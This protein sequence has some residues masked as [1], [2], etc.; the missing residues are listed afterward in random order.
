MGRFLNVGGGRPVL[1]VARALGH[2]VRVQSTLSVSKLV[3][4]SSVP[5]SDAEAKRARSVSIAEET[6]KWLAARRAAEHASDFLIAKEVTGFSSSPCYNEWVDEYFSWSAQPV[7]RS[8]AGTTFACA[9][10]R[11]KVSPRVAHAPWVAEMDQ[12][13]AKKRAAEQ[14]SDRMIVQDIVWFK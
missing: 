7:H 8:M 13:L 6:E 1:S 9:E 10:A 12:W 3:S 11:A 2:S 5:S 4:P 14:M